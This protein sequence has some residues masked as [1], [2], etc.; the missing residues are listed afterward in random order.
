[1][2]RKLGQHFLRDDEA[3]E[4]IAAGLEIKKTDVVVEIGPGHGEL[5][6][7][8]VEYRP[9]KLIAIEKDKCLAEALPR[10]LSSLPTSTEF[11]IINADA[12]KA[13]PSLRLRRYKLI[14]NIPFYITGRLLREL[15]ELKNKPEIIVLTIQKEVAER[16]TAQPPRMNLLAAITQFWADPEIIGFIPRGKFSPPPEV[17]SAIIRLFPKKTKNPD[18]YY[19][20][21]KILFKQPRKTILNN[22]LAISKN[23]EERTMEKLKKTGLVPSSRP[24]NLNTKMIILLAS[25]LKNDIL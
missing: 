9:K 4:K 24:Q 1:M 25:L 17:D 15:S 12:L 14:G 16:I 6:R 21:V 5:T 8:L 22:L 11:K 2:P 3:L 18:Q 20:F 10:N 23:R 19:R 13:L 7:H